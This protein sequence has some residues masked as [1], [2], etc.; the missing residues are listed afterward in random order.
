M[1][2]RSGADVRAILLDDGTGDGG[3]SGLHSHQRSSFTF[4]MTERNAAIDSVARMIEFYVNRFI[5]SRSRWADH[6]ED[7]KQYAW[8][9]L[10]RAYEHWSPENGEWHSLARGYLRHIGP[11][12][13]NDWL[14]TKQ[15]FQY[16]PIYGDDDDSPYDLVDAHASDFANKVQFALRPWQVFLETR[17]RRKQISELESRRKERDYQRRRRMDPAFRQAERDYSRRKLGIPEEVIAQMGEKDGR[18]R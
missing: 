7:M 5:V 8:L 17:K 18:R 4:A 2:E 15:R 12:Y 6:R 1:W 3:E 10:A 11:N 13:I 14:K 16:L 9:A